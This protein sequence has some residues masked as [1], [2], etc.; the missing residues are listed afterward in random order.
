MI[1]VMACGDVL[2]CMPLAY[3][4]SFCACWPGVQV[5]DRCIT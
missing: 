3:F 5:K 4:P 1:L 2:A